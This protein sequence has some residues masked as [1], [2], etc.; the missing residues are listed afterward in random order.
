MGFEVGEGDDDGYN[1]EAKYLFALLSSFSAISEVGVTC[2]SNPLPVN[3]RDYYLVL[4]DV[5]LKLYLSQRVKHPILK[6]F[7]IGLT[8]A[9]SLALGE[10]NHGHLSADPLTQMEV[11]INSAMGNANM[12]TKAG[13]GEIREEEGEEEDE[14]DS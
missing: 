4:N 11:K 5:V 10:D 12:F 6:G 1:L 3:I 9:L 13:V 14:G 8:K 2:R 7:E